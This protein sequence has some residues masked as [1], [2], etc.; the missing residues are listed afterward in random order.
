MRPVS[1]AKGDGNQ[2][3]GC[4]GEESRGGEGKAK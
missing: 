4:H 3:G 1:E 2:T